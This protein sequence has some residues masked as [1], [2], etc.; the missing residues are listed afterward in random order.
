MSTATPAP[1][2][3]W[4]ATLRREW[5][6]QRYNRFF[7]WHVFLLI[8]LGLLALIA[9]AEAAARGAAWW[10]QQSVIF[11]VSLSSI[12]LGLSSAHAET[13]EFPLLLTHPL[14]L[15]TWIGGKAAGLV[16]ATFPTAVLLVIPALFSEHA[17]GLLMGVSAAA[18]AVSS[19]FA[20]LGLALGLWVRDPVRGLIVAV[21]A[22]LVL[23][24]GT[25]LVL[26]LVA[27][28]EWVHAH[29][30]A[31]V[32]PLMANP[33]DTFRITILFSVEKTAFSGINESTLTHWW[34]TH[35]ALWLVLCLSAWSALAAAAAIAGARR[36]PDN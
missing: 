33:L 6:S 23:L 2:G 10:I 13:D 26:M 5:L 27:G 20:L 21:A 1:A 36:R 12:L 18:G 8:V 7:Y 16:L 29:P 31:W 15:R 22:W 14:P 3:I 32:A 19:A 34:I 24:I 35:P 30:W 17:F 9:P 25:D 28:S 4:A 11:I